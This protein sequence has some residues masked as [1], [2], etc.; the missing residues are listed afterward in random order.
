ML[1]THL[2]TFS[3]ALAK[4]LK[5]VFP[6][7][8]TAY[9]Q[10]RRIGEAGRLISDIF[11]ISDKLSIDGYLVT[12]YFEKVFNSL[13]HEFL[14]VVFKKIGFGNYLIEWIKILL[15]NQESCVI[16]DGTTTSYFKLEK[17]ARQGDL[18]SAYLF[19]IAL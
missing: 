7:L 10:N 9:V 16:N 14:L 4:K 17:G 1:N 18:I 12:I 8:M 3:K 6:S 5:H 11:N 2:K 19:I 13:D 15:T